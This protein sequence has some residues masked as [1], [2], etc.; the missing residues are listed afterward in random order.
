MED[1]AKTLK[2]AEERLRF[3]G[4]PVFRGLSDRPWPMVA[5]EG[6]MVRLSREMR[7]EGW[8]VWYEVLGRKGVVL[9]ALEART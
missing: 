6:R 3:L 8:S 7:V 5:W 9:F 4:H 2:R 1:F